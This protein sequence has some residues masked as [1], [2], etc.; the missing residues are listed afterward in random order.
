M[1]ASNIALLKI[2]ITICRHT[3][4]RF[5]PR[6]TPLLNTALQQKPHIIPILSI[7]R[8]PPQLLLHRHHHTPLLNIALPLRPHII[9]TLS[10]ARQPPR[11]FR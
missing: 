3:T 4:A 2:S 7:A 6:N 8:Q 1:A 9:P 10:I 11:L 5:P